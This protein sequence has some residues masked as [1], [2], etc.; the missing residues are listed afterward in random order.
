MLQSSSVVTK[1]TGS[2]NRGALVNTIS[3]SSKEEHDNLRDV[4]EIKI[5]IAYWQSATILRYRQR[6]LLNSLM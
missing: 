1:S 3:I 5:I 6:S 4:E 2:S